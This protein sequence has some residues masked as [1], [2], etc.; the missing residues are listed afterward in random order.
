MA[1]ETK[2]LEIDFTST[3]Q[4]IITLKIATAELTEQNKELKKVV[5]GNAEALEKYEGSIE[6]A[7]LE[8][9]KNNSAI[10]L[11]K[12]EVKENQRAVDAM[13]KSVTAQKGS[14]EANR[15]QLKVLT[16]QY[17]KL[18][19][20]TFEQTKR[21][22]DL[23]NTLKRQE[24][25]I[26]NNTR[27][28][29]NYTASINES[30]K[31]IKL[32]GTD[33][34][35]ISNLM[36][37]SGVSIKGATTSLGGFSK[38]LVATGVGAL[39]LALGYLIAN[40]DKVQKAITDNREAINKYTKVLFLISAPLALTIKGLQFL[41]DN[42]AEIQQ[43]LVGLSNVAETVFSAIADAVNNL[44]DLN[45]A[46]V[47]ESFSNLGEESIKS[48]Y[49][50]QQQ[51]RARQ[52]KVAQEELLKTEI[53]K[54]KRLIDLIDAQGNDTFSLRKKILEDELSLLK[55]G[56]EDYLDKL[57]E[58]EILV[59]TRNK[60]IFDE[61]RELT[62]KRIEDIEKLQKA[63]KDLEKAIRPSQIENEAVEIPIAP[64]ID[65]PK[66]EAAVQ[67]VRTRFQNIMQDEGD[68]T[69]F[70]ALGF[71]QLS[72]DKLGFALESAASAV[73]A[74]SSIGQVRN[75]NALAQI[76]E[77]RVAE[78]QAVE[79]SV[80]SEKEKAAKIANINEKFN[81]EKLKQE[82]DYARRQKGAQIVQ[83]IINGA[84]AV[85]NAL[86]TVKPFLPLGVAA[87]A[88]AATT[89]AVQVGV[90]ASQKL[91]EGG[92]V[93]NVGG[94]PHIQGGTAYIGED[95]NAFEVE[96]G[97]KIFVLKKTASDYIS[98]LSTINQMFGGKSFAGKPSR[99]NALGGEVAAT[100]DGGF[101]A[102]ESR[103]NV[104]NQL[105]LASI[106]KNMPA[107]V[108]R[109]SEINRVQNNNEQSVGVSEL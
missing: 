91:A 38:A 16:E 44:A 47:K 5:E 42:L 70:D 50:G 30:L 84:L 62:K 69:L 34:G 102:R 29:G 101:A 25:A 83:A 90:I 96:R 87:A 89:T 61:Q 64:T 12:Q 46:G 51:E 88:L 73:D 75:E 28:V 68:N 53:A 49:E 76:E 60:R 7:R 108:V 86:A 67:E 54:N 14:I 58:I 17:L 52:D 79:D 2:V 24:S 99:Y 74:I 85:T 19:K 57:N 39:V 63:V 59:A 92:E 35:A 104:E 105:S 109:V 82:K 95:G 9:E 18:G 31:G 103:N 107:P 15:A 41:Q 37:S 98:G 4:E 27:N 100:F 22:N 78:V 32:F 93:V 8:M 40:F 66:V 23:T 97:E 11:N 6:D 20:P 81:N 106:L 21:I 65:I 77:R 1:A 48:F 94:K 13:T 36:S 80:A 56:T 55:V 43:T 3:I 10:R 33:V 71:G 45:F 26:G 72:Q